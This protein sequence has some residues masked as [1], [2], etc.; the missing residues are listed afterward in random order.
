MSALTGIS[1]S[2]S[3]AISSLF[4]KIDT[5]SKGYIE[6]SDLASAFSSITS[7][8]SE[9]SSASDVFTQLDSDSDGK[10]TESEFSS[11][12]Q[13]LAEALDSQANQ[14]RMEG[15][16]PP[17]PPPPTEASSDSGFTADE[18]SEQLSEIGDSDSAR[19]T[20]ISS[21]LENFDAA[22]TNSDGKV[23][24]SEAMSYAE[25][26]DIATPNS[27]GSASSTSTAASTS[28]SSSATT[29]FTEDELTSQLSEIGSSDP[30]RSNLISSILENF[31]AADT[32]E[33]GTVS[34]TEAMAYA[35]E[36]EIST[37]N[38]SDSSSTSSGSQSDSNVA[39]A[40]AYQQVMELMRA[41]G[42]NAGGDSFLDT[43]SSTISTSA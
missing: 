37:S 10:V 33:D 43:L 23:S 22:D 36:N 12:I 32:N 34:N 2:Y 11:G 14:T 9:D 35:K 21:V 15:A 17:P 16:M 3:S 30:A 26:N 27:T 20:L 13:K 41:Y 39:D 7:T 31:D 40:K 29:G 24:N 18:L 25:A 19:S 28:S 8:S 4:S 1:S 5:T 38:A 42:I 6:E